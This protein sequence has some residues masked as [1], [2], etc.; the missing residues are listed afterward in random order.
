MTQKHK[1]IYWI[2]NVM[3]DLPVFHILI[4]KNK[5][6]NFFINIRFRIIKFIYFIQKN[7]LY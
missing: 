5:N 3:R 4:N 6:L 7:K 2:A 1:N